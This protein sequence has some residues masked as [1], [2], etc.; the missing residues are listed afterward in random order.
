MERWPVE[1]RAFAVETYL[2]NQWFC[3]DSEDISLALQYTAERVS[4]IA[5]LL[6][7]SRTSIPNRNTSFSQQ[8]ECPKSQYFF[9][10]GYLKKRNQGQR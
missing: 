9:L 6:S 5:I 7:L 4:Q 3:L 2:K 1:H 8:N 10:W